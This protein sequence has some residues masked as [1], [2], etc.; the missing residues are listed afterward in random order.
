M[1]DVELFGRALGLDEPWEVVGVQFDGDQRRLDL[2]VDF[3]K[4]SRF[5][6]PRCAAV[7]CKVHD[8]EQKTWRHLDFFEHRAYLTA[9]V[10]RVVCR[11]H[12]T[13]A[14]Q[15]PWARERS[16]FSLLFEA[17]VMALVRQM[18]VA[19]VAALIGESDMR[20]WRILH[21]YV[22]EAVE[23]QDLAGLRRVAIDET[24]SR[25][26]QNYVTVF[27]D[28]DEHRAVYVTEDRDAGTVQELAC[29]VDTHGGDA[30]AVQDV[31]QDMSGAYVAG[32]REHLAAAKIT[33]DRYHIRQQLSRA[34][35]EVRRAEAKQH[36]ALLKDTRYLWLKRPQNL[37]ERQQ[38]WL[39]ELL[40]QPL[41]TVRCYEHALKFDA[42]YDIEDPD[43]AEE[44]LRRW[45]ADVKSSDI[46]PLVQFSAMLEDHW[47]GV[48][49]WHRTR[50]NNGL[51][52]GLNSL[53]Q[54]A[55]RRARGYRTNRNYIA[56]IYLV[57]GKLDPGPAIT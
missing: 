6:C 10:P 26:G 37:T 13:L 44:Y 28:L 53:I 22:D 56:M 33:F 43:M 18:P 38:D 51:L 52:E 36:R 29:F 27:A 50:I 11:E 54:A 1:H 20:V 17:L 30:G 32:V 19:A 35:D 4:G 42:F 40:A 49:R 41:E 9:R 31:S 15:V 5:S 14:V 24:S 47:D 48:V 55:K 45:V 12:G 3:P 16:G 46:A 7:G 25:R 23:Q 21:H 57:V 39:D 2:R 34:I 8:S